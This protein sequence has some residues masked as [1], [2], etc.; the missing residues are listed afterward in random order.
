MAWA[1]FG[2]VFSGSFGD[3]VGDLL[4]QYQ[5]LFGQT[6]IL[7]SLSD[8]VQ[9]TQRSWRRQLRQLLSV[10]FHMVWLVGS[11]AIAHGF[12]PVLEPFFS[13]V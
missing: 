6:P 10:F 5:I 2:V 4:K 13:N 11:N 3:A 12:T 1:T 9:H 8:V 7:R